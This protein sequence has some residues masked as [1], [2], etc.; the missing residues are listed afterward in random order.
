MRRR[1]KRGTLNRARLLRANKSDTEG[2]L[3]WK[4]RDLNT[5]GFHFRRQ[6]PMS[7]YFLDFAEHSGRVA[8]EL[9]GSQHGF[10]KNRARDERR[11]RAIEAEGYIV[12]RFWN[13]EVRRNLDIVVE[14]IL[15]EI[16]KR[17]PPPGSLRSPTSPQGGGDYSP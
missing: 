8:I 3:W 2:L 11:D 10:R 15:R 14:T 16:G 9:D 1:L 4:L 12:L 6:V 5:R 17:R 13:A 7:G